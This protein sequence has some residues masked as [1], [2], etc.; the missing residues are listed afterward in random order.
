MLCNIIVCLHNW[1]INC[2]KNHLIVKF[3]SLQTANICSYKF[4][5]LNE[6]FSLSY[7]KQ[8]Y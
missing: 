5:V 3:T 8:F 7:L 2:D 1:R 4:H 6:I